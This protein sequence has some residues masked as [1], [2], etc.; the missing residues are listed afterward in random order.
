MD[1]QVFQLH[2]ND[3][4]EQAAK[5]AKDQSEGEQLISSHAAIEKGDGL[6]VRQLQVGL[7]PWLMSGAF[8]RRIRYVLLRDGSRLRVYHRSWLLLRRLWLGLSL[9]QRGRAHH[10]NNHECRQRQND[11]AHRRS[12]TS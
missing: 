2:V 12:Y 10:K 6:H 8:T 3:Q 7:S 11:A 9:G 1:R 4:A 5:A